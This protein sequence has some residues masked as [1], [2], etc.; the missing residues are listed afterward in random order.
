MAPGGFLTLVE[1]LDYDQWSAIMHTGFG[2]IL[3]MRTK[4]IPKKL[5]R[6]LLEKYD[7]WHNSL[8][9]VNGKLLIHEEDVYA[10]LGLPIGEYEI[11]EEQSSDADIEF[12]ES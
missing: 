2:G 6:S 1:R 10:T 5:A 12:L 4:L 3:S 11:I 7:P 8:N 9:L